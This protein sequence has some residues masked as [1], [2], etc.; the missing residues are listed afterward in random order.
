MKM[1]KGMI[2]FSKVMDQFGEEHHWMK[3]SAECLEQWPEKAVKMQKQINEISSDFPS[4]S[5]AVEGN[6]LASG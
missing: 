2:K 5:R 4:N 3:E 6:C 1:K